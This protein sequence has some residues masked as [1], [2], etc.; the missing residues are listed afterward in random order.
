MVRIK[1]SEVKQLVQIYPLAD[2]FDKKVAKLYFLL[3]P[4]KNKFRSYDKQLH[5]LSST[6][7]YFKLFH[8][9]PVNLRIWAASI[10]RCFD[11]ISAYL[12]NVCILEEESWLFL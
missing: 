4:K 10:F 11:N 7:V 1:K 12:I 6:H 9:P 2:F 3:Q 8:M 5:T